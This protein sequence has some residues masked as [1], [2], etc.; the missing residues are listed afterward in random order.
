MSFWGGAACPNGKGT[1]NNAPVSFMNKI[2]WL[3]FFIAISASAANA[4]R[5]LVDKGQPK[6]E[7]VIAESAQRSTRLAAQELQNT[8][9]KI[10]GAKLP[11]VNQPGGGDVN[12][13]YIGKSLYT[14]ALKLNTDGLKDGAY[15]IASGDSWLALL[16]E[17]TEFSPI[18][19]WAKHNADL[20]SGKAQQEWNK[21]TGA[22][23]GLPNALI[24]KERFNL[25]GNTGLPE[26][27][28]EVKAKPLEMWGFDERGSFNAVCGFLQHLGVRWYLP[29]ELGEVIPSLPS[30]ALPR[31][32]EVAKPDFPIRRINLRF[33]VHNRDIGQW[34]MR[35][36]MRDPYPIQCA[37]GLDQM[38][39]RP[40]VLS[41]HPEWFA[42]YGGKRQ[43]Q[44]GEQLHQLCYSNEELFWETVRYARAQIDHYKLETISIMPPDG[45]TAICQCGLCVGK[46]SPEKE[47][48]GRLSNHVWDFVN[49]VAREVG[50]THPSKKILNC[51]YGVYT[52]PPTQI[53][54]MEPNVVVSIVGGRRLTS[55]K[56]AEKEDLRKLREEWARKTSNPIVIFE[57][58]PFTD[59]GW[60]LP[61][62]NVHSIFEGIQATKGNSD[63]EDIWLSMRQD[64]D[65]VGIGFNHFLVYFTQKMYWGG[66]SQNGDA[67]FLEYCRLFYGPAEKPMLA[68][69]EFCERNWREMEK[70]KVLADKALELFSA[71]QSKVE[72]ASVYGQRLS[73]LEDFLKGLRSKS[74][75]LGKK[76]GQVPVLRLVGE[77]RGKIVIDGKLDEPAWEHCQ[78]ASTGQMVEIQT[79]K[80]PT[81]TT[82]VKATWAGHDLYFA[83]RCNE[84]PGEPVNIGATKKDDPALWYGDAVEILIETE[85]HSYYQIAISPSG[86]VADLDRS[87]ERNAWMSWDS[88]AEVATHIA[89]DHWT[90]EVRIPI[91]SDEND[92]LHQVIGHKPTVSLPWHINV[93]R[94][95]V[96]EDGREYSALS[97]TGTDHFH[98]PM[99]FAHFYDGLSHAFEA[100]E[101]DSDYLENVQRARA[102]VLK[103][104]LNGALSLYMA[105]ADLPEATDLQKASALELAT[106]LN[107]RLGKQIAADQSEAKISIKAVRRASQMQSLLEQSRARELVD[108]FSNE[109]VNAWPFWKRG[110]GFAARGRA[111][112]IVHLGEEAEKNLSSAL[113]WTSEP[114]R[115][116]NIRYLVGNNREINLRDDS[117][118]L[119][120]Y[121]QIVAGERFIGSSDQF[122]ALRGS[123]RILGRA[124]RHEEAVSALEK[125]DIP[126]LRG[127]WHGHMLLALGN[128][129][130][131]AGRKKEAAASYLAISEDR[132]ADVR[133]Q[134]QARTKLEAL[135]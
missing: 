57:N 41:A 52:L 134:E 65:K 4:D 48:R 29:G 49:R 68:F 84:H 86:A 71:A 63:G 58:Y 70:E 22:D 66:R 129:Q 10:S 98:K 124:G 55:D 72:P 40:E 121:E 47:S 59:R 87:A 53:E 116:D 133:V 91:T 107:R 5:F 105:A 119:S 30:I 75:Q 50:K 106:R 17:D 16:G 20:A 88:Q 24:Y 62:F 61:V 23:W 15:R 113:E 74:V 6:A 42:L 83:I 96:R 2:L 92:P 120:A 51:A 112:S 7:I 95:R 111:F 31:L 8:V 103:G 27:R 97:P 117:A 35:L 82:S 1:P 73:L 80:Q 128:A 25:D 108:T 126:R 3:V 11:I 131:A 36:G 109:D 132:E 9:L 43:V 110:D 130:A 38:T 19:P 39:N 14:E 12:H 81:F 34:G 26:A 122:E 76:R 123:A 45:Y 125:A 54:K 118:A 101:F 93:C 33:G 18:E 60:Y 37:H 78:P 21:I 46:D 85:S 89:E 135:R 104:D 100:T 67:M 13:I 115:R 99:K 77:A 79:G 64:F 102:A 127:V 90:A 44:I 28:K 94:Q 69:F 56:A 32:N 114:R